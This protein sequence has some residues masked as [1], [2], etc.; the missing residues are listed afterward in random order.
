MLYA[1]TINKGHLSYAPTCLE[2][3]TKVCLDFKPQYI[4]MVNH[5]NDHYH[6]L[7]EL[8]MPYDEIKKN[9]HYFHIEVVRNVKSY[10]E[11]MYSHDVT[12]SDKVG[13]LPYFETDSI[14]E[15]ILCFG[16]VKAVQKYGWQALRQYKNLKEFYMD[17]KRSDNE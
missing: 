5:A 12:E 9:G 16:P 15:Y 11:Y 2:T 13:E 1:I 8:D 4:E 7:I 3:I 14:I 10:I 17:S 6:A